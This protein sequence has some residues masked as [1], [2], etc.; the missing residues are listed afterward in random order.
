MWCGSKFNS[1]TFFIIFFFD[2]HTDIYFNNQRKCANILILNY[3]DN[4]KL[5]FLHFLTDFC[6]NFK[7][8]FSLFSPNFH[9]ILDSRFHQFIC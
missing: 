6:E 8:D 4:I 3:L 2:S 9:Q 5:G 1:T 7:Y